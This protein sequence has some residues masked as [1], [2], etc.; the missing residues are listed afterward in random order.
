M[1]T[2]EPWPNSAFLSTESL[3]QTRKLRGREKEVEPAFYE[4]CEFCQEMC[5]KCPKESRILT[6]R[7][8]VCR[9]IR[10]RMRVGP[11]G[12]HQAMP[13]AQQLYTSSD[14][15]DACRKGE[16]KCGCLRTRRCAHCACQR[17]CSLDAH[18]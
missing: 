10:M 8:S 18:A 16:E 2:S 6:C 5:R 1:D 4:P 14:T 9:R 12:V 13:C 15:V 17:C 11:P 3:V 7:V